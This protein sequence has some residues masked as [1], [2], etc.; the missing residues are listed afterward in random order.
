M[1]SKEKD[2]EAKTKDTISK[3][4]EDLKGIAAEF[5]E[6]AEIIA[7][8]NYDSSEPEVIDPDPK[9]RYYMAASD[10]RYP[11]HPGNVSA[12]KMLGY[13]L[14][15]KKVKNRKDDCVLVET[16]LALYEHRKAKEQDGFRRSMLSIARKVRSGDPDTGLDALSDRKGMDNLPPGFRKMHGG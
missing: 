10:E 11:S 6:F 1:S 5:P 4:P 14:S 2:Q 12:C 7:G 3:I 13:R 8:A 16:P 9:M 15:E